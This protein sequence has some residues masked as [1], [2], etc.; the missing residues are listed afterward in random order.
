MGTEDPNTR[1]AFSKSCGEIQL[2]TKEESKTENKGKESSTSL[3]TS[4]Q[5][6]TRPLVDP[7]ELSLLPFGTGIVKIFRYNPLKIKPMP[8]Y[9]T[10]QMT[11]YPPITAP[12]LGNSLDENRVFY[13]IDK[14][15]SMVTGRVNW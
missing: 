11:K 9:K 1:E 4:Q 3:S 15:N 12:R 5:R 8:W 10:S 7:Y 14:R 13:D 6:V 2:M